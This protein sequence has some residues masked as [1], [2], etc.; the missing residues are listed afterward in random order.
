MA[1]ET[2]H[3]KFV[4]HLEEM[5]Y[6]ENQLL[7]VLEDIRA[8]VGNDDLAEALGSHR[9]QT[10]NHVGRLEEVFED[11]G[12]QPRER[13]SPTFDALLEERQEFLEQ[14]ANDEDIRD[15]H[16]LG[17]VAKNEHMEIAGYENL[18]MLA[19]KLD[20]SRDIRDTL[21][22]NLDEEEQTKKQLKVLSD[23]STVR[24]IFARLT[25]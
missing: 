10:R 4:Y 24:K 22:D 6:I 11:I 8:D 9:E 18:L 16:D 20:L 15:L 17:V 13:A 12:E 23:D 21:E 25:G 5:Y 1:V 14:A 2:L 19:R 7:D 3:D